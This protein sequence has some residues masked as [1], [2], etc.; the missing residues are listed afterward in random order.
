MSLSSVFFS[1][2]QRFNMTSGLS[3]FNCLQS[4]QYGVKSWLSG[5][6]H[7]H[8]SCS[9]MSAPQWISFL[10]IWLRLRP[11]PL[12]HSPSLFYTSCASSLDSSWPVLC[13]PTCLDYLDCCEEYSCSRT[14]TRCSESDMLSGLNGSLGHTV[15][16]GLGG[17]EH[18]SKGHKQERD[19]IRNAPESIIPLSKPRPHRSVPRGHHTKSHAPQR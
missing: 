2:L 1:V 19:E 14:E 7:K 6:F 4:F 16:P 13:R 17:T 8:F 15:Q 12:R 5:L 10:P 18:G 11:L 9:L 3:R